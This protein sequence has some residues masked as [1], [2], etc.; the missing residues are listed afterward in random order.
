M[1]AT[2][3][4]GATAHRTTP[5]GKTLAAAPEPTPADLPTSDEFCAQLAAIESPAERLAAARAFV[6]RLAPLDTADVLGWKDC[7]VPAHLPA[8]EFTALIREAKNAARA[9][10]RADKGNGKGKRVVLATGPAAGWSFTFT[11]SRTVPTATSAPDWTIE[12]GIGPDGQCA[13]WLWAQTDKRPPWPV[14]RV[15]TVARRITVRNGDDRPAATHY[16][17]AADDAEDSPRQLVSVENLT[18]GKYGAAIG[19]PAPADRKLC[20]LIATAVVIQECADVAEAVPRVDGSGYFPELDPDVLPVGYGAAHPDGREAAFTAWRDV[21]PVIVRNPKLALCLGVAAVAPY[22]GALNHQS[23]LLNLT[24]EGR[25]GKT[26]GLYLGAALWGRPGESGRRGVVQSWNASPLGIPQYLGRLGALLAVFD[27]AGASSVEARKLMRLVYSIVEGNSRILGTHD[28]LGALSAGWA[29]AVLSSSN[30]SMLADDVVTGAGA[31]IP[32][33]LLEI[34]TPFT[35]TAEDAETLKLFAQKTGYGHVG[36][37]ILERYS[38][39]D[40]EELIRWAAPLLPIPEGAAVSRTII[41]HWHAALAGVAMLDTVLNTGTA[42]QDAALSVLR[43]IEIP[44]PKHDAERVIEW[45]RD[46]IASTP[47]EWPTQEQY[48][49]WHGQRPDYMERSEIPVHGIA[50]TAAGI[51]ADDGSWV[52]VLPEA[53][54][55]MVETLGIE[56]RSALDWLHGRRILRVAES[57][58][59]RRDWQTHVWAAGRSH[60]AYKLYLP[61]EPDDQL[62]G[63]VEPMPTQDQDANDT[64]AWLAQYRADITRATAPAQIDA[65]A[66]SELDAGVHAGFVTGDQAREL[67]AFGERRRAELVAASTPAP[68]PAQRRPE[69]R[70]AVKRE[71]ARREVEPAAAPGVFVVADGVVTGPAGEVQPAAGELVALLGSLA[72]G[73]RREATVIL[74]DPKGYGL[75]GKKP[76]PT[77][78][79]HK[80]FAPADAAGWHAEG[81]PMRRPHVGAWTQLE[82]P[83]H[84]VIR[85]CVL[86]WLGSDNPFPYSRAELDAGELV[87]PA[88]LVRRVELFTTLIGQS[89]RGTRANTAVRLFRDLIAATAK[90]GAKF[91]GTAPISGD[92]DALDWVWD[93][94]DL[95][96]VAGDATDVHGF[97]ANKNH[98]YPTREVRLCLDDLRHTGPIGYDPELAGLFKIEVPHWPYPML[99]APTSQSGVAWVTAPILK[100]YAQVGI[101]VRIIESWSGKGVQPEGSRRFVALVKD[102]LTACESAG[103]DAVSEAVKGLYQTLHGKLRSKSA[104][105]RHDWGL[106]IRDESWCNTLRKAYVIAGLVKVGDA[107]RGAVP[108]YADMDELVYPTSEPT[109][110]ATAG[111]LGGVIVLGR[112]L[113]QFKAKTSMT[114]SEWTQHRKAA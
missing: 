104:I 110:E 27:E 70:A 55:G 113:G 17:I 7:L 52:G 103:E 45:V 87:A 34:E 85:L 39:A 93:T 40:V 43:S 57:A 68:V 101:E 92:M 51:Q 6:G 56:S 69:P 47:G 78:A 100:L 8:S 54:K 82:H 77:V 76:A 66:W 13:L 114:V 80:G 4:T 10:A 32:A 25:K 59:K 26:T 64:A 91:Q 18:A 23:F 41:Q 63:E 60:R 90:R 109:H 88:E 112:G 89:Y 96:A 35:N 16:L 31:G 9:A 11:D 99:P 5:T 3:P 50:A 37:A 2:A 94:P 107:L 74:A 106:A 44:E 42:L 98:L 12:R 79:W 58:R 33:R 24:G 65:L 95:A 86:P 105:T 19:L 71:R 29:G 108:I 75:G 38:V 36:P 97:D 20:E 81:D 15:P 102:A 84:G 83:D 48:A 1:A 46:R 111:R 61:P 22:L 49:A 53:W 62:A 14:W 72:G 73:Q 28:Q 21:V 67:V 30:A